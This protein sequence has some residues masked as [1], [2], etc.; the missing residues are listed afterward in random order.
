MCSPCVNTQCDV[1]MI[2]YR[3]VHLKSD[4]FTNQ[5]H[6]KKLNKNKFLKNKTKMRLRKKYIN[7]I[8]KCLF[9]NGSEYL[10]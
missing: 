3:I 8:N 9:N 6:P 5:C 4:N 2:Y 7:K 1:Q 10:G